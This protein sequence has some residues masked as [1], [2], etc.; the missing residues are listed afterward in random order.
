MGRHAKS[1]GIV[2]PGERDWMLR[3][4]CRDLPPEEADALFFSS[5]RFLGGRAI[6]SECSVKIECLSYALAHEQP[7][8]RYGVWGGLN[9]TQRAN[10]TA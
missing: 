3:A 5:D 7:G 8:R 10:L 2:R 9:A 1:A 4:N 6:C